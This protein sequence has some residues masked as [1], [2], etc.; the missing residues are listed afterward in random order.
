MPSR[1][2][3][4]ARARGRQAD[5]RHHRRARALRGRRAVADA[6]VCDRD[7]L[8]EAQR[9]LAAIPG[10]TVLIHD[11]RCAAE[12]RRLRKRGKLP[13]PAERV[14][15]NERVCE[16]CGDCGVKS[17]C[18]SVQPVETEFGRKTQIHQ[19]S[20]NK[21]YSCLKGDCP[22]FVTVVPAARQ[23]APRG[24]P[25][26]CRTLPEPERV[27][28]DRDF[29]VRMIGIGGTGVVTVNQ[30]LATAA[31]ARRQARA[32]LDQTGLSQKGGPVVSDLRIAARA[33][34]RLEQG[35][36]PARADLY[37]GFDLLG[38]RTRKNL[39]DAPTRS[40]RSPSSR[41]SEVPTGEMVTDVEAP[42]HSPSSASRSTR[43]SRPRAPT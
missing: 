7:A 27:V 29:C 34:R 12:K 8:D 40:A 5:H 42:Q 32:G 19:S 15:I 23:K 24:D 2:H 21:D 31:L 25:A 33:D 37:L 20:C 13:D 26:S 36:R 10:V 22:S 39:R 16:G 14:F 3:A 18:L 11:Q 35:R 38:R 9:E 41:P 43:S 6:E 30:V 28:G 1:A 17:N 4:L